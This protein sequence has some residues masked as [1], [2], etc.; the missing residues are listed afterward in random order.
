MEGLVNAARCFRPERGV[1][2]CTYAA[3]CIGR[4]LTDEHCRQR[5]GGLNG[6]AFAL[7]NRTV[8]DA[9]QIGELAC[10]PGVDV[11][12]AE[13]LEVAARVGA[14]VDALPGAAAHLARECLMYGRGLRQVGYPAGLRQQVGPAVLRVAVGVLRERLRGV[15]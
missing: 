15:A 7:R 4:W 11:V 6:L 2:F 3:R 14:V 1:K 9:P 10:E 13:R 12:D 8:A 5:S